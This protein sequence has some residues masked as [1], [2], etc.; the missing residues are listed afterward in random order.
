MTGVRSDGTQFVQRTSFMLRT[1]KMALGFMIM[2]I[3]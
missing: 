2:A 3:Y 1:L